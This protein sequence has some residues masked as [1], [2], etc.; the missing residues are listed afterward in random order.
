MKKSTKHIDR[1]FQEGFSHFQPNAPQQAWQ[2][3]SD[4][5]QKNKKQRAIVP[6]WFFKY[7]GIAAL[8][9]L[10]FGLGYF[11]NLD[12]NT[13][14]DNSFTTTINYKTKFY[15][16]SKQLSPTAFSILYQDLES[17]LK[18]QNSKSLQT[19]SQARFTNDFLGSNM[20]RQTI[21][22]NAE[23]IAAA[24][25]PLVNLENSTIEKTIKKPLENRWII[26]TQVAP[27]FSNSGS[28]NLGLNKTNENNQASL[29]YGVNVAYKLTKKL[30]LRTGINQVNLSYVTNDVALTFNTSS[31]SENNISFNSNN[32]YFTVVNTSEIT[33][34]NGNNFRGNQNLGNINQQLGFIEIPIELEYQIIDKKIGVNLIGGAST[35]FVSDNSVIFENASEQ[36]EIGEAN[37]LN[38]TSF[39]TNVGVG[40]NYGLSKQWSFNFEPTFKYQFNTFKTNNASIR[41]YYFGIFSGVRFKF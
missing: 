24:P 30:N 3:I 22:F 28:N 17:I 40:L 1:V 8:A 19:K 15:N 31:F 2:N 36:I 34:T 27:V 7:A 32:Q 18:E 20:S 10:M 38:S 6:I 25:I 37:N 35:L 41:P 23:Q 4:Q 16:R 33:N 5:L 26:N 12:N 11:Y 21:I 39:S 13:L 29:A 9:V 14:N